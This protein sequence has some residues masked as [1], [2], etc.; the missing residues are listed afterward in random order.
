[1]LDDTEYCNIEKNRWRLHHWKIADRLLSLDSKSVVIYLPGEHDRDAHIGERYGIKPWNMV[2]VETDKN[3]VSKLRSENRIVLHMPLTSA[4]YHWPVHTPIKYVIADL[5]CGL[6]DESMLTAII[7]ASH[8]SMKKAAITFNMLRGREQA[9]ERRGK[10]RKFL[11]GSDME[12]LEA[13]G[14]NRFDQ[15]RIMLAHMIRIHYGEFT[16]G[17]LGIESFASYRSLGKRTFDSGLMASLSGNPCDWSLA[18]NMTHESIRE[19]RYAVAIKNRI[20]AALAVRTMQMNGQVR[21]K[22]A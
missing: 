22:R 21:M 9:T 6:S 11:T 5:Q 8:P 3:V 18:E 20:R 2:A 4:L 15:L 10:V 7:W 12:V 19:G 1:M 14:K 17:M 16:S 13:M